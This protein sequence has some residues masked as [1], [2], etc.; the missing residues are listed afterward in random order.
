MKKIANTWMRN[1]GS[2][3]DTPPGDMRSVGTRNTDCSMMCR[4]RRWRKC[5]VSFAMPSRVK[6]RATWSGSPWSRWGIAA[7]YH[8]GRMKVS[9]WTIATVTDS[10][11]PWRSTCDM[12]S[13]DQQLP[14]QKCAR[15]LEGAGWQ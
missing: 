9:T 1:S 2:G 3:P 15:R 13:G 4:Q 10:K 14:R 6:Q 8:F 5:R 12:L 11:E 7:C